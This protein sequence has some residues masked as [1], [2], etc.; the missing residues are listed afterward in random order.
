MHN[1]LKQKK[2]YTSVFN[3][4]LT[5]LACEYDV[6]RSTLLLK[7]MLWIICQYDFIQGVEVKSFVLFWPLIVL[8]F[9][10]TPLQISFS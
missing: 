8:L 6:M 7:M 2:L 10:L 3:T 1:I 5:V 4:G 9:L